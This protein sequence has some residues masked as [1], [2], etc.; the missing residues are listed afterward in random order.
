[1]PVIRRAHWRGLKLIQCEPDGVLTAQSGPL[2]LRCFRSRVDGRWSA[3]FEFQDVP[4]TNAPRFSAGDNG[5]DLERAI[6]SAY[7]RILA[8]ATDTDHLLKRAT[9]ELEAL[10]DQAREVFRLEAEA[11]PRKK[12]APRKKTP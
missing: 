6:E 9:V 11:L 5:D 8:V 1:M 4:D 7:A 12:A 10:R 2:V 3:M